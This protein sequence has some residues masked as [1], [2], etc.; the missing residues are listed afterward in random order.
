MDLVSYFPPKG[1]YFFSIR[2][3]KFFFFN[4]FQFYN[5]NQSL[6]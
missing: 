3:A 4:K 2:L 1:E 5:E 6:F